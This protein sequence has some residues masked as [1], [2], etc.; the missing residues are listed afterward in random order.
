MTDNYV[1]QAV[2][3]RQNYKYVRPVER[4]LTPTY[5]VLAKE[6]KIAKDATPD[7][8]VCSTK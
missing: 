3:L 8:Q 4:R 5:V 6:S 1:A 2:L 7:Q